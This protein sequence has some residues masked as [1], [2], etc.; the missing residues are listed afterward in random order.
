MDLYTVVY[1]YQIL[2][3]VKENHLIWCVFYS[4]DKAIGECSVRRLESL[5]QINTLIYQNS[6]F[7][8]L[9]SVV[10]VAFI[11]SQSLEPKNEFDAN[12]KTHNFPFWFR[13]VNNNLHI[14]YLQTT[15]LQWDNINLRHHHQPPTTTTGCMTYDEREINEDKQRQKE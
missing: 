11:R 3:K 12:K 4:L 5:Q 15:I 10:R 6:Y 1:G 9:E 13:F 8:C 14:L 7:A 2:Y